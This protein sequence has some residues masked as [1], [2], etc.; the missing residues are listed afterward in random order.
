M[1]LRAGMAD[2]VDWMIWAGRTI[3]RR[4]VTTIAICRQSAAVLPVRMTQ[5]ASNRCMRSG[6]CECCV[7]MVECGWLPRCRIM[8]L[9][10]GMAEL[11]GCMIRTGCAAIIRLVTPIAIRGRAGILSVH[12]ALCAGRRGMRSRQLEPCQRMVK[13]RGRPTAG[14]MALRAGMVVVSGHMIRI[15]GFVV[16]RLM[17][18]VA[19]RGQSAA[20]LPVRMT[21]PAR[22]RGMCARQRERCIRMVECGWGV[23]RRSVTLKAIVTELIGHMIRIGGA[24]IIRLVATVTILRRS[25]VLAIHMALGAADGSMRSSQSKLGQ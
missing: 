10:A 19:I 2:L 17:A 24:V 23:R 21:Q 11:I 1:A 20:V 16:I 9:R 4:L 14:I 13:L 15:H 6:Q 12:M 18:A 7:R 22:N 3:I 5:P 25:G 8:A